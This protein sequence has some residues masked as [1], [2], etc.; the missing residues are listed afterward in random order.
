[1]KT[2]KQILLL[3]V[4]SIYCLGCV[5][6][7]YNAGALAGEKAGEGIGKGIEKKKEGYISITN[8]HYEK[9]QNDS[10]N[11]LKIKGQLQIVPGTKN[12]ERFRNLSDYYF[13]FLLCDNK[14]KLL[15]RIYQKID[16]VNNGDVHNV[17]VNTTHQFASRMENVPSGIFNLVDTIKFEQVSTTNTNM[18]MQ[19][20]LKLK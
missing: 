10:N 16:S 6:V 14:S 18:E 12:N 13:V 19:N 8:V 3:L 2:L 1:M 15:K 11:I 5:E 17:E 4:I 20:K 7:L 9:Q